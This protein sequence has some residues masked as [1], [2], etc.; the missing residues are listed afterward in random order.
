MARHPPY[1]QRLSQILTRQHRPVQEMARP[2]AY[3]IKLIVKASWS[4][5]KWTYSFSFFQTQLTIGLNSESCDN[6]LHGSCVNIDQRSLPP[7]YICAFCAQTPNMR[8]GRI[9]EPARGTGH[10]AS[11]PLA[12]K[13]FKS[14]RWNIRLDPIYLSIWVVQRHLTC[15]IV[16]RQSSRSA[17]GPYTKGAGVQRYWARLPP[18]NNQCMYI[19]ISKS[20][21]TN[22]PHAATW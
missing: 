12:H 7:V 14:F 1:L 16:F 6:W 11:S 10:P 19:D 13:S 22:Q 15:V 20:K 8:G 3:A 21:S 17:S 18:L 4:N 2:D 9:R 5:G